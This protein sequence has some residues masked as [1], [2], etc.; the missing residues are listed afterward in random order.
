MGVKKQHDKYIFITL[1]IKKEIAG[2]QW[3]QRK[4]KNE[5]N[6][7]VPQFTDLIELSGC[8]SMNGQVRQT[9]VDCLNW[10]DRVENPVRQKS[11]QSTEQSTKKEQW[12][13]NFIYCFSGMQ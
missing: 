7:M 4:N 3:S 13:Q 12:G 6:S 10:R 5:E 2:L 11:L 9:P 1:N 8:G